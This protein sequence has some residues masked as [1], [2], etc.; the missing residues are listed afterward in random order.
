[1][2]RLDTKLTIDSFSIEQQKQTVHILFHYNNHSEG[3][4]AIPPAS[5]T[6]VS[7]Y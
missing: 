6:S 1:M 7:P 3:N 4:L 5:I 2:Y